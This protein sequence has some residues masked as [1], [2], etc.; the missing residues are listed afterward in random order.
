MVMKKEIIFLA[1][2]FFIFAVLQTAILALDMSLL[3]E[4]IAKTEAIALG[5]ESYGK[6]ITVNNELYSIDANCTGVLSMAIVASIVFSLSKP[7][8]KE[9]TRIF[10]S[11]SL[12]LFLL[13]LLRILL[14]LWTAKTFGPGPTGTVH[15]I[16]WFS[17]AAFILGL[18]Y[19]STKKIAKVEDFSELL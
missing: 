10:L 12:V 5:L 3:S 16:A 9:K 11:T 17:T 7:R 1:K 18:W 8:L 19:Y 15:I 14:V 13:N 6:L 2:F 4:T